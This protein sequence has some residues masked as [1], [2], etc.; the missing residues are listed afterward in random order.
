MGP[1]NAGSHLAIWLERQ[2][3]DKVDICGEEE[4]LRIP[5]EHIQIAN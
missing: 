4:A 5:E 3:E 2:P 1:V